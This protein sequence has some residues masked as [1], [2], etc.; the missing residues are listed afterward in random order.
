MLWYLLYIYFSCWCACSSPL[1]HDFTFWQNT[2]QDINRAT[3]FIDESAV[4]CYL[5]IFIQNVQIHRKNTWSPS[6]EIPSITE[7]HFHVKN[8]SNYYHPC[9]CTR[10]TKYG[11]NLITAGIDFYLTG[12]CQFWAKITNCTRMAFYF[13]F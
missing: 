6:M 4:G 3:A 10:T 5:N 11:F 7:M 1:C 8:F 2:K 12:N 13:L 9:L